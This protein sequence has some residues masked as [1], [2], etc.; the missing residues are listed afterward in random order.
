MRSR[1]PTNPQPPTPNPQP[2]T[3]NPYPL[4]PFLTVRACPWIL[5]REMNVTAQNTLN[6][7]WWWRHF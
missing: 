2:P 4:T 6:T 7:R 5:Q 3:P 1:I